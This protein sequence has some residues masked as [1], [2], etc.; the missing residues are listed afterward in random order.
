MMMN[1]QQWQDSGDHLELD[2]HNIFY[3]VAGSGEPLLLIHGYPTAS[4]DYIKIWPQLCERFQCITLDML[5]FGFSDKPRQDYRIASQADIYCQLLTHLGIKQCHVVSH[6][7]GDTVAQ[8][9]LARHNEGSLNFKMVSL[10][11]LNGGLFAETHRP[12]FIQKLL[13]TP[14]GGLI[15]RLIGRNALAKNLRKVF[16]EQSQPTEQEIDQFWQLIRFNNGHLVMYK[17]IYYIKERQIHRERWVRAL[18]QATIPIRFTCGLADPISGLHMVERYRQLIP[19]PDVVGLSNIGHYPQ[20]EAP[21]PI[22]ESIL[23]VIDR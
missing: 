2:G 23:S 15:V 20:L 22:V 3:Q 18:Q 14:L 5:G 9:L 10:H 13:L 21:Q 11:L 16:A 17:L 12:V 1:L 8:E 6:D 4:W 19:N 7:Y